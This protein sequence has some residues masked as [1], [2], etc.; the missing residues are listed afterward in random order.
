MLRTEIYSAEKFDDLAKAWSRLAGNDP[1]STPF[2]SAEWQRT[3]FRY[4]GSGKKSVLWTLWEGS[5]LVGLMPFVRVRSPWWALRPMG[6]GPSDYLQPIAEPDRSETVAQELAAYLAE[7]GR[8]R[9]VDVQQL[10][11]ST[12]L[13]SALSR[14]AP[15]SKA[16]E[17]AQCL[18]L[19]LPASYDLYL[20]DL[21]KSLR[22]DVK[23]LD[24][25]PFTD[26]HAR[27]VPVDESAAIGA[28]DFF[29]E[30]H[31]KRW[32]KRGLP[33]AFLGSKIRDFHR[34][35]AVLAAQKGWLWMSLLELDCNRIG[36]IYAMRMG[37]RCYFYQ[38]GF[39]PAH[40][41]LSPGSLLVAHTIRRAIDEG[42]TH[43]DFLRG[44]EPY[45][46]RWK[47]QT[48]YAN[49]RI[50]IGDKGVMPKMGKKWNQAAFRLESKVRAR[51]EGRG[52]R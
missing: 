34:E 9:L 20:K 47:P 46:R 1:T 5:D 2:Q 37:S 29:F 21:G 7:Q 38:S 26:G 28:V 30:A 50:L 23:K 36:A 32:S 6:C 25:P 22:Y 17:Q 48:S 40:A 35:W 39:D 49:L 10:R 51:F 15:E 42:L 45:K 16:L 33:G 41:A 18:V 14:I 4:F 24:K 12:P 13:A 8:R 52:L 31:K 19:E 43:F 11:E 3:W 27:I 44:D